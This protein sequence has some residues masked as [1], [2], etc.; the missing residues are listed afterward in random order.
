MTT[1]EVSK[2]IRTRKATAETRSIFKCIQTE[3]EQSLFYKGN[4]KA[5]DIRF[6]ENYKSLYLLILSI[7]S[8][9]FFL[10]LLF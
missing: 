4:V 2:K 1:T 8:L 9:I 3:L 5:P 10:R 7:V 6:D